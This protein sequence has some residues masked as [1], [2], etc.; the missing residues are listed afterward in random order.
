MMEDL[1]MQI[2]ELLMNSIQAGSRKIILKIRDSLKD[3]VIS[4]DLRDDGK[5]MSQDLVKKVTDPFTTSRTTR[6]VGMGVAF[7]KG[8]TE[9]CNGTFAVKSDVGKGTCISA[10]VQKDFIDTPPIGDLGEMMMACIQANEDISYEMIYETDTYKFVFASSEIKEQLAGVSML[11]SS[12]LL[13]IKEYI[14]QNVEGKK[15][16]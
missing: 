7:M 3:N 16:D 6:K 4:I 9:E 11:D 10:T 5:G 15:E 1:A 14:N 8:L 2:L 13:W 12:I